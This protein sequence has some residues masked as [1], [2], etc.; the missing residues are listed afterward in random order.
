MSS[1][2]K[3][4]NETPAERDKRLGI[5]CPKQNHHWAELKSSLAVKFMMD[6][7]ELMSILS[8]NWKT[9]AEILLPAENGYR[10]MVIDA[11]LAVAYD[12][13]MYPIGGYMRELLD[14]IQNDD[15]Q[16]KRDKLMSSVFGS[17][18]LI[19]WYSWASTDKDADIASKPA[20]M[21]VPAFETFFIMWTL[22]NRIFNVIALIRGDREL[23]MNEIVLSSQIGIT[24]L[25]DKNLYT[26][27]KPDGSKTTYDPWLHP[28]QGR[29]KMQFTGQY[30]ASLKHARSINDRKGKGSIGGTKRHSS[31][32]SLNKTSPYIHKGP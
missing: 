29:C 7:D 16:T 8:V 3:D 31:I 2:L 26:R 5:A 20:F 1:K 18:N 25:E 4:V 15:Q 22:I 23:P 6:S 12:N 9:I 17:Y 19:R 11:Y 14:S 24:K 30:G 32:T 10:D 27:V 13:I 28:G 21:N